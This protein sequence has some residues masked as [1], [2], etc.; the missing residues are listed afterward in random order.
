MAL[1]L[2]EQNI[3]ALKD[4][5]VRTFLNAIGSAEGTDKYGYATGFGGYQLESLDKHPNKV[6]K[7][8]ETTGKVNKTTAAGRYQ[9]TNSTWNEVAKLNNSPD[10]NELEQDL[11]AVQL[12]RRSGALKHILNDDYAAATRA[13]GPTWASLPTS[14]YNQ[15]KLTSSKWASLLA[16]NNSGM[17]YPAGPVYF[18]GKVKPEGIAALIESGVAPQPESQTPLPLYIQEIVDKASTKPTF[19]VAE[20]KKES[21]PAW[22]SN[23]ADAF[24]DAYA[25][26]DQTP[27]EAQIDDWEQSLIKQSV[28]Q[29]ADFD[30]QDA[31]AKVVGQPA[32]QRYTL[33]PEIERSIL[34]A[35]GT[36]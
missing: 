20:E 7:F 6:S 28:M 2:R 9:F 5:R 19:E 26:L 17:F 10:F 36:E 15:P 31:V 24:A 13:A 8:K 11:G 35:L 3:E 21:K 14:P 16:R 32:V 23:L 1:S 34:R 27:E 22:T 18:N 25:T 4:P 30:R 33:P 12:L 29:Q